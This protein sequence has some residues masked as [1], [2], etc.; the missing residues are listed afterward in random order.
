MAHAPTWEDR[1]PGLVK[2][3][4][5]AQRAPAGRFHARAHWSDGPAL[6]R[7]SRRQ[8]AEAAVGVEGVTK[9]AYGRH[10]AENLRDLH[11]RRRAKRDRHQPSRRVHSPTAPGQRRPIGIAAVED[12]RV[13]DA[14]R[15]GLE[16]ID[17]QAFLAGA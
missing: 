13:Q 4:E 5:R 8:R 16:A 3:G 12:Q 10:R 2:G 17:E 9:A 11:P 1:A 14:G 15:E 6:A 7:A